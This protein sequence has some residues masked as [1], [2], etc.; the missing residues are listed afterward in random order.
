MAITREHVSLIQ[1]AE[2]TEIKSIK[3]SICST[4]DSMESA[5]QN[6]SELHPNS[7]N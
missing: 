7:I 3:K 6:T 2:N 1:S 5:N 4:V